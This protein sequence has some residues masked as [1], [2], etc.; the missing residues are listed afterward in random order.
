M[1]V[2]AGAMHGPSRRALK[3]EA[4]NEINEAN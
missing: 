1:A 2:I 3:A 4:R